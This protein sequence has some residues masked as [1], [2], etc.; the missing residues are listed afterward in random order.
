[1]S[2]YPIEC[3]YFGL[4]AKKGYDL[5]DHCEE[6]DD[7][8]RDALAGISTKDLVDELA[9]R[10]GVTAII[11][12]LGEVIDKYIEG[13]F[14]YLKEPKRCQLCGDVLVNTE[15][16][17]HDIERGVCSSCYGMEVTAGDTW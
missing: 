13:P 15:L 1:M 5:V 10:E 4:T 16:D 12:P 7:N 3:P 8:I 6:D 2:E 17:D 9:K 14:C 11:L